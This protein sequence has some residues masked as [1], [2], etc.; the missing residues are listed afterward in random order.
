MKITRRSLLSKTGTAAI[1]LL[2]AACA[3]A[4]PEAPAPKA[5]A[6]APASAPTSAPAAAPAA[7]TAAPAAPAAPTAPAQSAPAAPKPAQPAAASPGQAQWEAELPK[8]NVTVNFWHGTDVTT[9][10][11]Y[12]ETFIPGYKKL[13]P[14]YTI[15]DEVVPSLDQKM[16]VALAT[17]TAPDMYTLN[18]GTIQTFMAKGVLSPVPPAAWGASSTDEMMSKNFMPNVMNILIK[19]GNLYG[20]PNQMNAYSMMINIRLF[21]EAGLDPVKDAPKTWDDVAKLNKILTKRD[22]AGRI[23]QKGFEFTWA[24]PDQISSYFQQLVRQAGGEVLKDGV[25]PLF[26][27]PEGVKAMQTLKDVSVDPKVTQVSA[28]SPVQDFA[29]EQNAM[30]M[31]GPNGAMFVEAINPKMKGNYTYGR[32]PQINPD[33]PFAILVDFN[34][35][36]H[37]KAAEDKKKVAHDFIHYMA[38][39]PEVWLKA[40]TQVIPVLSLRTSPTAKEIMPYLDV[41]IADLLIAQVATRT[42]YAP[43]LDS[44][45]KAAAERVVYEGQDVK[46]SLDQAAEEFPKAIA[47]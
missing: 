31:F 8:G 2:A 20:V 47:K 6:P 1:A 29:M 42:E 46:K 4:A 32:L 44:V 36:V 5:A 11:L 3:P 12:S 19:D 26:N 23:T 39:Q 33:K 13:R 30:H 45:L 15:S 27:S 7:P 37:G 22:A 34:L 18:V 9:N 10:K 35:V 14:N 21:K 40:T 41:A 16:V 43:Q 17:D 28:T 38:T 24:R 25:T